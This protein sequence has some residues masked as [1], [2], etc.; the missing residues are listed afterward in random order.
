M[1][2]VFSKFGIRVTGNPV[3]VFGLLGGPRR[4]VSFT[5]RKSQ[6]APERPKTRTGFPAHEIQFFKKR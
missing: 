2:P 5:Q 4:F 3:R 1:V 6:G